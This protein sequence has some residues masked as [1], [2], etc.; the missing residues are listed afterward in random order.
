MLAQAREIVEI[1]P[2]EAVGKCVLK[3]SGELLRLAPEL[4]KTALETDAVRFHEGRICGAWPQI[5]GE[6]QAGME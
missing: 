1:L 3:A 5:K 6:P 2:P 4:L